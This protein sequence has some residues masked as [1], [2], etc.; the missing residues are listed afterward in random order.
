MTSHAQC[1]DEY[2]PTRRKRYPDAVSSP[3][4]DAID[5]ESLTNGSITSGIP[6][7]PSEGSR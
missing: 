3:S 4:D 6:E 7:T 2:T 5:G 1:L